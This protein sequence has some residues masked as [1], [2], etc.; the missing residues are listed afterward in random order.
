MIVSVVIK[1]N[2]QKLINNY[3]FS[4]VTK[5]TNMDACAGTAEC[6]V[7]FSR[8]A[9]SLRSSVNLDCG[10]YF[11]KVCIRSWAQM[12]K[13]T[14]PL[15]RASID[16]NIISTLCPLYEPVRSA[17]PLNMTHIPI[18]S[19]SDQITTIMCLI[20]YLETHLARLQNI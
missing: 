15:C 7:C 9:P 19:R 1:T 20:N 2:N 8:L 10:H 12:G 5:Q 13:D 16:E 11:C 18:G 14:C 4:N 6:A 3:D 17:I